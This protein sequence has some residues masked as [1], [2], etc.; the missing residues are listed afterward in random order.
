[1]SNYPVHQVPSVKWWSSRFK[2]VEPPWTNVKLPCTPSSLKRWFKQVQKGWSTPNY[3]KLMSNYTVHPVPSVKWWSSR[4]EGVEPQSNGGSSRFERV[5]PSRTHVKVPCT[6]SSFSQTVIRAGSKGLIHPE[7]MSNYPVQ[8][9]PSVKWW[10]SRFEGIETPRTH[11]KPPWT[12]DSLSQTVVQ[13]GSKGLNHPELMSNY[14]VN[15]IPSVKRRFE[16]IWKGWTT[17]NSCQTT[18]YTRFPQSNGGSSW[19]EGVEPP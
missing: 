7:L 16:L 5:Q 1:M 6:P 15:Q 17:L 8:P 19:F 14:A 18:L 12:P 9:V 3:P 4:F 13:A 11:V 10:S 2:G